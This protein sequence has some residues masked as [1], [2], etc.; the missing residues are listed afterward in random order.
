MQFEFNAEGVF[1][2]IQTAPLSKKE[3]PHS[4]PWP[5]TMMETA[6]ENSMSVVRVETEEDYAA[7]HQ[8]NER[9]FWPRG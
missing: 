1:P 2:L 3:T 9:A 6:P 7:V 8:V 4:G 5:S